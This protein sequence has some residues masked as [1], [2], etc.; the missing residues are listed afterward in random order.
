MKTEETRRAT[1]TATARLKSIIGTLTQR[2]KQLATSNERLKCEIAQRKS[3]EKSLRTSEQ[4]TVQLLQKSR[5]MQEELRLLSRRL[6]SVQEEERKRISRELHDVVAQALTG[7][8]VRLSMLKTQST[9]DA[10]DLHKKIATT[11][12]LVLKSVEIVHRF[13][14]DLRP[15]VL[16][17]LGLIPAL[18]SYLKIVR[19]EN[20]LEIALSTFRGVEKLDGGSEDGALPCR[21]GGVFQ[22]CPA[23]ESQPGH[24]PHRRS[25]RQCLHGYS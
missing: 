11:Q 7:I 15:T 19:E 21:S 16:D 6:L 13:A 9:A 24:R 10:S 4:T 1:R 12:R 23:C 17:D 14:R 8:N 3:V 25:Q 22:C 2:T 20:G 5:R 18:Q